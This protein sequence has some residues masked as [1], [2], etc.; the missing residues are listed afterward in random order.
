MAIEILRDRDW[1]LLPGTLCT[2]EVFG[3]FLDALGV[4]KARRRVVDLRYPNVE[5]YADTLAPLA[6]GAV[7]CGFSLGAIVAAHHAHRIDA[8]RVI[9][10][11]LNPN[12]D[13]PAKAAGRHEL[14][15]DVR[16]I[17]GGAALAT[18]LAP[19]AGADPGKGRADILAM[20]D[21]AAPDIE[22]HTRLALTR[23]GAM[24]PLSNAHSPVLLLTGS[25]DALCPPVQG[26]A[27][28]DAAP[29]G[30]FM[31]LPGLGHYALVE[32]PFACARA[33]MAWE[34]TLT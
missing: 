32:D 28:A 5:D 13:D 26:Q 19:L 33:V 2:G 24:E 27:A 16:A 31:P 29:R 30:T 12:P 18:R 7:I 3:E 34:E 1:V 22:A 6:D 21:S 10:F 9:L 20:A 15:R 11:G 23:P 17:G 25:E 4:M 8:H 14:V